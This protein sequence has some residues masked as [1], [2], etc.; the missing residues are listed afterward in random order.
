MAAG[1]VTVPVVAHSLSPEEFG[2]WINLTTTLA[3]L[4]FVDFGVGYAVIGQISAAR[5][6]NDLDAM[7]RVVSTAFL[8]L[9]AAALMLLAVGGVL[10][11]TLDWSHILGV[12]RA[13]PGKLLRQ[14]LFAVAATAALNFPLATAGRVYHALQ[15]G[16]VLSLHILIGVG[17]Q[18]AALFALAAVAPHMRW[19]LAAY[20][21]T[22]LVAGVTTTL[23]LFGRSA[24]W[25]RPRMRHVDR[26]TVGRLGREGAQLFAVNMINVVAFNTDGY[27]IGHYL[28]LS[29]VPEFALTFSVFSLVPAFASAFLTPLWAAYREARARGD[30]RWV[31]KAYARS[32]ALTGVTA[33]LAAGALVLATPL[34]LRA[35][36]SDEVSP[37]SVGL[38]SALAC[39]VVVMCTSSAVN[40]VLNGLGALGMQIA[41]GTVMA[42]LNIAASIWSVTRVGLAGPLWATVITQ[43][44]IVLIPCAF[45]AH[46]RLAATVGT[47]G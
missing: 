39:Y 14:T 46:R 12:G 22:S 9:S 43:T 38:R 23:L 10:A 3:M 41:L 4:A 24:R 27:V 2:L 8:L 6:H 17:L 20:L 32:V 42:V 33:V 31:Q 11:L 15:R 45:H 21:V 18:V 35:W 40:I 5:G 19:F 44:F 16:H 37:P 47:R 25:L 28:G 34:L 1:L 36:V 30:H 26:P 13:V 7:R 29:R